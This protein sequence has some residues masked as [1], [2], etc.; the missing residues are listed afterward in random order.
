MHRK[1]LLWKIMTGKSFY[2]TQN[3]H[4]AHSTQKVRQYLASMDSG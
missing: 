4:L 1:R 2:C 3:V